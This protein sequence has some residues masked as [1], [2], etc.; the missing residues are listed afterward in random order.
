MDLIS[1]NG[2]QA[3]ASSETA[4]LFSTGVVFFSWLWQE[5]LN[6]GVVISFSTNFDTVIQL[7]SLGSTDQ[8][9]LMYSPE[10]ML[11]LSEPVIFSDIKLADAEWHTLLLILST[12]AIELHVDGKAYK[13]SDR[14][15]SESMTALTGEL[16]CCVFTHF[17]RF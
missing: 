9:I 2:S 7:I 8:V 13:S 4:L 12:V 5:K 11:S 10:G 6:D 15:S 1:L 3:F 14:I 16:F 17:P